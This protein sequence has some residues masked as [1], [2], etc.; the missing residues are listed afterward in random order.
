MTLR[1]AVL[2]AVYDKNK[3]MTRAGISAQTKVAT[4]STV[5]LW[6]H[7]CLYGDFIYLLTYIAGP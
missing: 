2:Y 7:E 1:C 3:R 5:H 6:M 4:T